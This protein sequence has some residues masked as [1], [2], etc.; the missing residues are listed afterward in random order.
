MLC[1]VS[2]E[3]LEV[4]SGI[5]KWCHSNN[6]EMSIKNA[7]FKPQPS[8]PKCIPLHQWEA[9]L[10]WKLMTKGEKLYKD[11]K[12]FIRGKDKLCKG[13]DKIWKLKRLDMDMDKEGATLKKRDG[14]KFLGQEKH[15]SRGSR[16]MNFD[17][18][19]LICAYSCACLHCISFQIQYACLCGVC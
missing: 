16:L 12:A 2:Q 8:T 19:H 14:S 11:M 1:V 6:Q 13:R 4:T 5:Y 7:R 9:H 10:L 18:L 3:A 17:W 15:T